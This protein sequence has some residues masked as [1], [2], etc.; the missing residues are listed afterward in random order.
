M[1]TTYDP[2]ADVTAPLDAGRRRAAAAL[3]AGSVLAA[4]ALS[5]H[6]RGGV[7]DVSFV[8]RVEAAPGAW[9][10]G[11]VI[12]TVGTLLLA[13]GLLAVPALARGGGRRAV[14]IGAGLSVVGA[15]AS[16]LGDFAHG[17][18]A[19]VLVGDV[20]AEQSLQIQERFFTQPMI[21]AMTM[22]GLLLPLGLLVLGGALLYARAVPVPAALLLLVSPITVQ[23]GYMVTTLPMP[24]MVLPLVAGLGWLS[25]V[26]ARGP[27]PS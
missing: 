26:L 2:A 3:A 4:T 12:M 15:V 22:P 20:P 21:A 8:H 7:E 25:L 1:T 24:V 19:Y 17:T 13:L 23:L 16:G 27:R 14:A 18:L 11:H 10:T 6:L 5:M 9:L